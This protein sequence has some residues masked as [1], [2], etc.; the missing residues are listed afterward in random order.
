MA[1]FDRVTVPVVP[2]DDV[3][4][5]VEQLAASNERVLLGIAG[6]PGAGKSTLSGRLAERF[7]APIVGMDGFL[8]SPWEVVE[9]HGWVDVKGAPHTFDA[10]GFVAMLQRLVDQADETVYAPRYDRSGRNPIGSA[11]PIEPTDS[12]VLIEGNYLLMD[13]PPWD[14][15]AGLLTA[16][17]YLDLDDTTR[18][19]RLV[20]RHIAF[21]E[22]HLTMPETS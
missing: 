18:I 22:A 14:R 9:R 4:A 3:D 16:C 15:I 6:P 11:V 20:A 2:V 7:R 21:R 19:D 8:T 10:H 13:I 17:L 12:L 1:I 5:W